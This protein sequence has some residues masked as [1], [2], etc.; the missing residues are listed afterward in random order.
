MDD[1]KTRF[2][3]YG[4]GFAIGIVIVFFFLGGKKASCNWLPNDRILNIIQQK[5]ISIS[6]EVREEMKS[7]SIDSLE[8]MK[9]LK[10][11]EIDFSKSRVKNDPCRNYWI[12]SSDRKSG[13][14][15]TVELCDSVALVNSLQRNSNK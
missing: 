3:L 5:K 9:I 1:M 10:T 7:Y 14:I 13:L 6:Q 4:I 11:G 15:I 2:T 8:I 12:E